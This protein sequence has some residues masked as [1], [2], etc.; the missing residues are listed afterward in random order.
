MLSDKCHKCGTVDRQ[1]I[2]AMS[3][4]LIFE[5]KWCLS[6]GFEQGAHGS[7]LTHSTKMFTD[8]L[9]SGSELYINPARWYRPR[10]SEP[11]LLFASAECSSL[12]LSLS[13]PPI[14]LSLCLLLEMSH[15]WFNSLIMANSS[16]LTKLHRTITGKR[17]HDDPCV[18]VT[19]RHHGESGQRHLFL[20]GLVTQLCFFFPNCAT[21]LCPLQSP[22]LFVF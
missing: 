7:A 14:S 19:R 20:S 18:T 17:M 11:I 13:F 16:A 2:A 22:C 4:I 1:E 10:R 6:R 5:W 8:A 15:I 9:W 21:P 12:S 3:H